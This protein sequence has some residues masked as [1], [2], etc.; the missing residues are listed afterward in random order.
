LSI[1]FKLIVDEGMRGCPMD[2]DFS[3]GWGVVQRM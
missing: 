2:E 3:N 1:I